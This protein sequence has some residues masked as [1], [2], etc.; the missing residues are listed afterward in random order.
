[1]MANENSSVGEGVHEATGTHD[2]DS[3]S[4][5]SRFSD[6]AAAAKQAV[7]TALDF[8]QEQ[9]WLAVAG[10]FVLGYL[11]AQLVKRMD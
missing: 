11:T 1:M 5:A 9:P 10:A 6:G 2:G 7:G 3:G 8:V 4:M